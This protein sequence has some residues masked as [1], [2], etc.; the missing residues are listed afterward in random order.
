MRDPDAESRSR[1]VGDL[2]YFEVRSVQEKESGINGWDLLS[3]SE[4]SFTQS[5]K[6][7]LRHRSIELSELAS[8]RCQRSPDI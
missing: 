1:K 3:Q 6:E 2:K 4:W 8:D 5:R 7:K